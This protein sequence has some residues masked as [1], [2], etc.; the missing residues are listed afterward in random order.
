MAYIDKIYHVC[1]E[2]EKGY[3]QMGLNGPPSNYDYEWEDG[4]KRGL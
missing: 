2:L 1:T 4:T 3:V